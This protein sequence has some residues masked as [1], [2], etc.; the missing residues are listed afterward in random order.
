M[1]KRLRRLTLAG[2]IGASVM[3]VLA[4]RRGR[5]A[6]EAPFGR[7]RNAMNGRVNPWLMQHGLTGGEH[8]E[9]GTIEHVGRKTGVAHTT[10][11][12]PTFVEDRVW[13]PLPYGEAS[14]WAQNVLAAGHCQ[15][16]LHGTVY[17]LDEPQIVP[18]T[19]NPML[20]QLAARFAGW[21]GVRYLRL[22]RFA[23]PQ[24]TLATEP[25]A[26]P[27]AEREPEHLEEDAT[28]HA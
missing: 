20:P 18:A 17:R 25:S 3:T 7:A 21:L 24:E 2:V 26:V 14:Q 10:P 12:Y 8:S 16:H 15:L 19:E 5:R 23:E 11:V 6:G 27:I 1:W 4:W 13:I 28:V 9:I 22:H